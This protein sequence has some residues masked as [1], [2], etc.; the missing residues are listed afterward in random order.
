MDP[1][2]LHGL[3]S[4]EDAAVARYPEFAIDDQSQTTASAGGQLLRRTHPTIGLFLVCLVAAKFWTAVCLL[5]AYAHDVSL[6]LSV[7]LAIGAGVA[8]FLALVISGLWQMRPR[9]YENP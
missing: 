8:G 4:Y 7:L 2:G 9:T 1:P 5:V 6:S 3:N